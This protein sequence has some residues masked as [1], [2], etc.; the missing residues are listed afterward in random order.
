VLHDVRRVISEGRH[1]LNVFGDVHGTRLARVGKQFFS[2]EKNQKTLTSAGTRSK[3]LLLLF[4]RK[5][6]S[7]LLP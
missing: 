3:S 6:D 2:E 7:S 5:E 1:R 4:F